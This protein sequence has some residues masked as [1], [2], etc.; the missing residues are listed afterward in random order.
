MLINNILQS[1]G[2]MF[3]QILFKQN[4]D[5]VKQFQYDKILGTNNNKS[6]DDLISKVWTLHLGDNKSIN[7]ITLINKLLSRDKNYILFTKEETIEIFEVILKLCKL[8]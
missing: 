8:I 6:I 3:I 7:I 5:F 1:L 4:N 2:V